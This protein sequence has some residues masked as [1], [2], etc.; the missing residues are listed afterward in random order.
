MSSPEEELEEPSEEDISKALGQ[1]QLTLNGL[2]MPLRLYGQGHYVDMVC[3][4][5]LKMAWTL[6]WRLVGVDT[7]FDVEHYHW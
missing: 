6:H 4:A 3:P 7:P 5:I 2:M 1:F